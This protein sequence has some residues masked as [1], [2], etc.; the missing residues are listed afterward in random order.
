[1]RRPR[2]EAKEFHEEEAPA[3]VDSRFP[4]SVHGVTTGANGT[5]TDG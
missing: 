2:G 3:V 5:T 1:M 4:D